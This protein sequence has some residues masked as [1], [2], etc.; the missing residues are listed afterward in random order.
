MADLVVVGSVALDT[1]KTPFGNVTEA[2]GGSATYF[3]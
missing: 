3:S 2:L 1:V